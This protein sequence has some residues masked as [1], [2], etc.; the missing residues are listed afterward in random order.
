[1]LAHS[2]WA[3]ED[4]RSAHKAGVCTEPSV[5]ADVIFRAKALETK[6][7]D[8]E[9]EIIEVTKGQIPFKR[10]SFAAPRSEIDVGFSNVRNSYYKLEKGGIYLVYAKKTIQP[11]VFSQ[12][13]GGSYCNDSVQQDKGP[14]KR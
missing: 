8:T 3:A 4:N 7:A 2:V 9:M 6:G 11:D 10:I 5:E 12:L 13:W 1:M 14:K